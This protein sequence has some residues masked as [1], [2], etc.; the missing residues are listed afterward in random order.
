MLP[1][2]GVMTVAGCW[3]S[4][5]P[6]LEWTSFIRGSRSTPPY[7]RAFILK[8]PFQIPLG[9]L[10]RPPSLARAFGARALL[11]GV[12][13]GA[14]TRVFSR[15]LGSCVAEGRSP[16]AH[17]HPRSQQ[18]L[19][20]PSRV[21]TGF[22]WGHSRALLSARAGVVGEQLRGSAKQSGSVCNTFVPRVPSCAAPV[23]L[24]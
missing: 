15:A 7:P 23:P 3:L 14:Q 1:R 8:Q 22:L 2:A 12:L 18:H 11:V 13:A 9:L 4:H 5:C 17:M 10:C 24:G 19:L 20:R 6:S 16:L 21:P